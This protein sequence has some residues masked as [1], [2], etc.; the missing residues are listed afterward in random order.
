MNYMLL[1]NDFARIKNL[2]FNGEYKRFIKESSEYLEKDKDNVK[3]RFMR[4]KVYKKLEMFNEA[5]ADLKYILSVDNKNN[6]ALSEL[7]FVLYQTKEYEEAMNLLPVVYSLRSIR[8]ESLYTTELVMR[9]A[10]NL[11]ID[12]KKGFHGDY[13]TDQLVSYDK[14]RAIEHV[15]AHLYSN[16]NINSDISYFS[17]NIDIEALFEIVSKSLKTAK[18]VNTEEVL[19]RYYF[20]ISNIGI[21]N[22]ESCNYI[23][24]VVEPNTNNIITMYPIVAV[25]YN[26]LSMLDCDD[27]KIIFKVCEK[28]KVKTLSRIDKFNMKYKVY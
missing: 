9:K 21:Y 2:Y 24:V 10:L 18:R 23:K 13:V 1:K 11:P 26:Y 15:K 5:I 12:M 25:D 3:M 8:P 14:N 28:E 27:Y 22:K 19:E 4:A 17:Q 16:L 20:T 7:Y 6:H